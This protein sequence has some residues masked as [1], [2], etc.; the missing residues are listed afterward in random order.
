[1]QEILDK[2]FEDHPA[3]S[4]E[5]VKFLS[6]NTSVEAV[7][8]LTKQMSS[9]ESKVHQAETDMKGELRS[10]SAMGNKFDT[11]AGQIKDIVKQL[12]KVKK[13]K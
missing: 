10:S 2:N 6:L 11:L 3:V 13:D 12:T 7:D 1:M 4:Q 5:L 9:F 8:T